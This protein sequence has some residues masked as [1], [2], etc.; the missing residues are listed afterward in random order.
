MKKFITRVVRSP[1]MSEREYRA[2]KDGLN[3][4]F[5]ATLG[6]VLAGAE[7]LDTLAFLTTLV[8]T[9]GI[10]VTILYIS[11]SKRRIAYAVYAFA[12]TALLPWLFA[13]FFGDSAV[14]PPKL[15]PTLAAWAAV[16]AIIEF[17]PRPKQEVGTPAP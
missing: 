5:G 7:G 4:V 16:M 15:Q 3:I 1:W 2:N 12:S 6:F 11:A 9:M 13:Q 8:F 14:L 10:V 17:T